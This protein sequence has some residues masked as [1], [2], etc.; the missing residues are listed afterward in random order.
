MDYKYNSIILSKRDTGE[1]DRM[2]TFY[3]LESGRIKALAAGVRKPNSKL[4][5]SLEPITLAEI[6]IARTKGSG[7]ITNSIVI[8]YYKQIKNNPVRLEQV[9]FAVRHFQKII[10]D[11]E[12]DREIFKLLKIFLECIDNLPEDKIDAKID[13]LTSGFLFKLLKQ[14]G[15]EIKLE[16]CMICGQKIRPQ[17]NFFSARSGGLL[18]QHCQTREKQKIKV[19][20]QTIKTLRIIQKNKLE[21]ILKLK[22]SLADQAIIRQVFLDF[23]NWI[24]T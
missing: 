17:G 2:Y 16:Q 3:S 18:C 13:I 8:D 4:A 14:A 10:H 20:S 7:K 21:S 12:M 24:I 1:A 23:Y 19:N 11:K 9:F 5:G 15:Y 6:F 22:I